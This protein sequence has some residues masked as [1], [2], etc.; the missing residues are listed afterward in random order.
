M[1]Y[2]KGR[3]GAPSYGSF[4]S[5]CMVYGKERKNSALYTVNLI[6][7]YEGRPDYRV[8][9]YIMHHKYLCLPPTLYLH[10]SDWAVAV[11]VAAIILQGVVFSALIFPLEP[12]E[13]F[14]SPADP[15]PETAVIPERITRNG[16][17]SHTNLRHTAHRSVNAE[18]NITPCILLSNTLMPTSDRICLHSLHPYRN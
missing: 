5:A 7:F 17:Q 9:Y 2:G 15:P 13:V 6:L 11:F 14:A 18:L 8:V 12:K 10:A 16:V 1:V 4:G 3:S